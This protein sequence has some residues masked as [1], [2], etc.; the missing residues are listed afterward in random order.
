MDG[1]SFQKL[2]HQIVFDDP[3]P[4]LAI[5]ANA[6]D[7]AVVLVKRVVDIFK[8]GFAPL[9]FQAQ[10]FDDDVARVVLAKLLLKC[11]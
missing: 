4:L 9:C 6:D 7:I 10:A 8:A 5:S 1:F 2:Q 11:A 3:Q